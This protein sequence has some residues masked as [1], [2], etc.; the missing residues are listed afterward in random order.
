MKSAY[1][2]KKP[3]ENEL[4]A[5]F[6][7]YPSPPQSKLLGGAFECFKTYSKYTYTHK[8]AQLSIHKQKLTIYVKYMQCKHASEAS[9]TMRR[10]GLF[11]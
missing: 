10:S 3:V 1:F 4:A 6:D 2:L 9:Q 5:I 7:L 11:D 8:Q